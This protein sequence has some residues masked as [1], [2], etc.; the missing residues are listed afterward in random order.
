M[1]STEKVTPWDGSF[2]LRGYLIK[3][4]LQKFT[5]PGGSCNMQKL[6][7]SKKAFK[8]FS[9]IVL[10]SPAEKRSHK[11]KGFR[12]A[13]IPKFN[14]LSQYMDCTVVIMRLWCTFVLPLCIPE[15][16]GK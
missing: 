12:E 6:P 11:E 1:T 3:T 2:A 4:G 10:T 8:T 15:F 16:T 13:V 7:F 9:E 5:D 14:L